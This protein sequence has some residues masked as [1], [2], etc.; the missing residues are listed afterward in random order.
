VKVVRL[1]GVSDLRMHDEPE[2]TP[3]H[4]ELLLRVTAVG[5]CG[6][7]LNWFSET[8]ISDAEFTKP[9]ILGHEFAAEVVE[10]ERRGERVAV[11]PAIPC[12]E[13]DRCHEGNPNLC[14]SISFAGHGEIDGALRERMAWPTSCLYPLPYNISDLEGV[15]LEPLGVALHS[16]SLSNIKPGMR[17]GVFGCGP[18]GLLIVQLARIMGATQ[19]IATDRLSHRLQAAE[20]YGATDIFLAKNGQEQQDVLGVTGDEGVDVAF[21]VAG[22]NEAVETAIETARPG[23]R[24][25]FVGIPSDDRIFFRASS[26][27]R[28]GLTILVCR[29]MKHTY[30][31]AIRL[32]ER[33][34]VEVSSLVTHTFGLDEYEQAF[35]TA[36]RREGIKIVIKLT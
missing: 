14:P 19:I 35:T 22:E 9:L 5:I 30:P 18:I 31:R 2:P 7:D 20:V 15:M 27:R 36:A 23:A 10:G 26:A 21:E 25:V 12:G 3:D 6:S 29:R 32:V 28:K 4:G 16:V 13:C 24:V 1:H 33:G 11:D 17:V 8:G 34:L